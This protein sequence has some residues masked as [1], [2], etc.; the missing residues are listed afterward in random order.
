[1]EAYN[2]AIGTRGDVGI[3]HE[4]YVVKAGE[5]ETVYANM[6]PFGLATA[7]SQVP[8]AR[9]GDSAAARRGASAT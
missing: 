1:M 4:T 8:V 5:Y 3:W 9:K 6:P 7:G 2:R